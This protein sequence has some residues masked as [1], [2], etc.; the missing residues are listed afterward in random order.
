EPVIVDF[1]EHRQAPGVARASR[2]PISQ[3]TE[4]VSQVVQRDPGAQRVPELPAEHLTFLVVDAG[5]DVVPLKACSI[6]QVGERCSDTGRIVQLASDGQALL[7]E[8][9]R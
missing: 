3:A 5:G 8:L 7:L 9:A 2:A 4:R 6:A 1:L